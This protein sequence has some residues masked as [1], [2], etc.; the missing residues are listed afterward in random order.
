M[1][2]ISFIHVLGYTGVWSIIFAE[3]GIL[4]GILLPG[5][6]LLFAAGVMAKQGHFDIWLMSFG[7]FLA[8]LLGNLCGYWLGARYGLPFATRYA[9]KFVTE[10]HIQKTQ[11]LFDKYG[12]FGIVIARFLPVARTVAPFLA[13]MAGMNKTQFMVYTFWGAIIWG[14]G[15]PWAG[16]GLGHLVPA[17]ALHYLLVPIF[18][19]ILAILFAPL[20]KKKP[21]P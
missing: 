17:E 19:I 7:C 14:A 11:K 21:H 15:L 6:T 4:F 18:I 20:F 1:D 10:D 8:A 2:M 16:Y 12:S 13:G 5:D 3:T 9:S